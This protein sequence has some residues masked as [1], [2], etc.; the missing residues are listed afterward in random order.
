MRFNQKSSN[1]IEDVNQIPRQMAWR[2]PPFRDGGGGSGQREGPVRV[3]HIPVQRRIRDEQQPEVGQE[4][5]VG[6]RQGQLGPV[7]REGGPPHRQAAAGRRRG[8]NRGV[9]KAW[10]GRKLCRGGHCGK[11]GG[12]GHHGVRGRCGKRGGD[13]CGPRLFVRP[14][15]SPECRVPN[16]SRCQRDRGLR[17][18][19][20]RRPKRPVVGHPG[21][22]RGHGQ[23]IRT[24]PFRQWTGICGRAVERC[25][26]GLLSERQQVC[27]HQFPVCASDGGKRGC[28]CR[29]YAWLP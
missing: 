23:R 25:P 14:R 7:V 27:E 4:R 17:F 12:H 6:G 20:L 5:G 26:W 3:P 1:R 21:K 9:R 19:E 29:R 15:R 18:G 16:G 10:R 2:Q 8:G 11:R 28:V 24:G 13:G 22:R